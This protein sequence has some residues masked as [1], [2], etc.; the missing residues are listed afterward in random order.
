MGASESGVARAYRRPAATAIT[1][2]PT[3]MA[4]AGKPR[5]LIERRHR[6]ARSIDAPVGAGYVNQGT[7]PGYFT[8][9]ERDYPGPLYNPDVFSHSR[10]TIEG[11]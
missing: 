5:T 1:T 7:S 2:S 10:A 3:S 9:F 4:G 8:R 6:E 11:A